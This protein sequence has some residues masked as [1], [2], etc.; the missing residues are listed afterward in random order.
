MKIITPRK[1]IN[2][3]VDAPRSKSAAHRILIAAA[4][5]DTPTTV[6]LGNDFGEDVAATLD[7][8]PGVG[9]EIFRDGG[10]VRVHPA[11]ICRGD[12]PCRESGSTL[13]FLLPVAGARGAQGVFSGAGRLPERP[14]GALLDA[15][16]TCGVAASAPRLPLQLQGTF[17]PPEEVVLPGNVSSQYVTGFLFALAAAG[18][19]RIRLRSALQSAGYVALTIGVLKKFGVAVE[20]SADGFRVS[21][22]FRSPGFCRV[23]GDWS[24]GAAYLALG[25]LAGKVSV[26]GLDPHSPQGD[27]RI[28]E[29]L[30]RFGAK[31][32]PDGDVVT[33]ETADLHGAGEIDIDPS[34]DLAPVLA[35]VAA[36]AQGRTILGNAGRLRLKESDRLASIG[37]MLTEL[38]ADA[39]TDG[40]ALVIDGKGFIPGGGT[41]SGAGDHRIVMAAALAGCAAKKSVSIE[42]E[43]AVAKSAPDFFRQLAVLSGE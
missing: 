1:T 17:R 12:F 21:G 7:C 28:V 22:K 15:L 4:L 18:G 16:Q 30:R 19:G 10:C 25:A 35:A 13:R 38:G 26:R 37:T 33:A 3:S 29:L 43:G 27:K 11:G 8:L 6:D 24:N 20:T 14:L 23:E 42:G 40:D 31:V 36:K 41:V 9:A 5:A 39:R 32:A 34:I 2:G